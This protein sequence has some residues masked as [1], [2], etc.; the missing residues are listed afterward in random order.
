M[1]MTGQC[2]ENHYG[3]DDEALEW[4]RRALDSGYE[5][6]AEDVARLEAAGEK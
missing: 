1:Y 5:D 2:L 3:V 4:Y 6:A